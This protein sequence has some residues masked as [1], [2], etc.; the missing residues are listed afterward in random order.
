MEL[1]NQTGY[2]YQIISISQ[3]GYKA[4]CTKYYVALAIETRSFGIEVF[5]TETIA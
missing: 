5:E 1:V 4:G 3:Q 2:Y